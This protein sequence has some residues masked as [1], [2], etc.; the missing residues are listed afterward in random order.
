VTHEQCGLRKVGQEAFKYSLYRMTFGKGP[1]GGD[2]VDLLRLVGYVKTFR[3]DDEIL[4]RDELAPGVVQ[5]PC[6]LNQTWP[7][8]DV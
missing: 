4:S 8:V 6:E 7:I 2:A 5:L 1:L 3:L